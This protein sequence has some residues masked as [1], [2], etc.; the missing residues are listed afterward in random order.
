[1]LTMALAWST[2]PASIRDSSAPRTRFS[3]AGSCVS[4][5]AIV[6]SSFS[7][8]PR[9][10]STF[11]SSTSRESFSVASTVCSMV[12]RLRVIACAF[13]LSSQNPGVSVCSPSFSISRF[14]L[15]RSKVP[16]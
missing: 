6:A 9:S 1:M 8:A 5:S 2:G 7:D 10:S 3:S 4:T 13:L 11:A 16:P 15:G 14:S 12:E